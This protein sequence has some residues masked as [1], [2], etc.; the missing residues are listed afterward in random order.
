[1]YK[2]GLGV[3]ADLAAAVKWWRCAADSGF[4]LASSSLERALAEQAAGHR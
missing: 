1:M 4:A 3:D 2:Q